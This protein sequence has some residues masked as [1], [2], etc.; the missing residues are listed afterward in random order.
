MDP[1]VAIVI[2]NYNNAPDT[3]ACLASCLELQY[4]QFHIW[5]IDNGSTDSSLTTLRAAYANHPRISLLSTPHNLG[6]AGGCNL[7]IKQAMQASSDLIW[8]LNNDT[9]VNPQTLSHLVAASQ[10]YPTTGIFGSK[11]YFAGYPDRL[12]F[13]GGLLVKGRNHDLGYLETDHGQFDHLGEVDYVNGCS[14]LI[15]TQVIQQIGLMAT[16]YF[17]YWEELDWCQR[18]RQAGWACRIVPQSTLWHRVS[19]VAG[20][21]PALAFRYYI[22]NQLYY[23]WRFDR[24][25][26]G[27]QLLRN[28]RDWLHHHDRQP[29]RA[30]AIW[31]GSLDFLQGRYG[32]LP[33][34]AP[35]GYN[36]FGSPRGQIG[37]A[38]ATRQTLQLLQHSHRPVQLREVSF[39]HH[40]TPS[41]FSLSRHPWR[42]HHGINLF[43]LNPPEIASSLP[44]LWPILPYE[45]RLNAVVPFWELPV[46]PPEW[47]EV[48]N[49]MDAV[50]A[51]TRYLEE[52]YQRHLSHTPVFYYPQPFFPPQPPAPNRSR[53]GLPTDRYLFLVAFDM[54]S[55]IERKNP[56]GA[57]QAFQQAFGAHEPVGLVIKVN[58]PHTLPELVPL[59]QQ[60][61]Q[62]IAQDPRIHLLDQTYRYTEVLELFA[63]CDALVS[64]HRAEGLGLVLMEC[65]ALGKPV[66]ATAW[67]GNMDYCTPENT[68]LVGYELVP[69]R[70]SLA[71]YQQLAQSTS[72]QWAQP[73][74]EEAAQWMR[75]LFDQPDL[76]QQ[77]GAQAA[78]DMVTWSNQERTQ[79]FDRLETLYFSDRWWYPRRR[80]R[81]WLLRQ[82][83]RFIPRHLVWRWP[84]LAPLL[85]G[86]S[87]LFRSLGLRR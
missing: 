64:L 25:L 15:R 75:R 65:M 27:L 73:R 76:G 67:S 28:T 62:Q 30:W 80:L 74:C 59:Y 2:V 3:L 36:L 45:S 84:R 53:F 63:S 13:A 68:A 5:L 50:L 29:H 37:L 60:L 47:V 78:R 77:L 49:Q 35:P 83:L 55:D 8:L 31:R 6:F 39:Q 79:V 33:S 46:L 41:P 42:L 4:A 24:R 19:T 14:L 82:R 12:W 51:P 23:L 17:M 40:D 57:I 26:V 1:L 58:N 10:N 61:V 16:H 22:R 18:A 21:Q 20:R 38:T 32:S 44:I 87:R 86:I 34:P 71:V 52:V 7:G 48:L 9:T 56:W 70:P 85:G 66:I 69:V 81:H 54:T 72:V 43:H 11:I